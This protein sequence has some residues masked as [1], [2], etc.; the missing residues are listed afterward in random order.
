MTAFSLTCAHSCVP[1]CNKRGLQSGLC[2]HPYDLCTELIAREAG[3]LVTDEAGL[4]LR[5][6]FELEADVAWAG[7]ANARLQMLVAP[8]PHSALQRRELLARSKA[9]DAF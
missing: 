1:S 2:C 3:V 8:L 6:P 7:Y 9:H 5:A 4:P